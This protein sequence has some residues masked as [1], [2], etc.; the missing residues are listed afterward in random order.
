[1]RA[2]V[3]IRTVIAVRRIAWPQKRLA[4]FQIL[5]GRL[6]FV[7]PLKLRHGEMLLRDLVKSTDT[8]WHDADVRENVTA[9]CSAARKRANRNVFHAP[10]RPKQSGISGVRRAGNLNELTHARAYVLFSQPRKT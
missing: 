2:A 7:G 4:R 5:D 1:M 9:Q 8:G 10:P 3:K 6:G